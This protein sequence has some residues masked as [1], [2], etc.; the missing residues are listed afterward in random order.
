MAPKA[1][2][3]KNSKKPVAKKLEAQKPLISRL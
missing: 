2:T 1:K 3:S